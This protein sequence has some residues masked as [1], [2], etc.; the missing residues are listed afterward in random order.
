MFGFLALLG[1]L[2]TAPP[3]E[4]GFCMCAVREDVATELAEAHAV[5]TGRVVAV[6]DTVV[7]DGH[8][9]GPRVRQVT[10]RVDR[11]WKGVD[12]STVVVVTGMS[13]GSCGFRFRRG[14]SYL[15]FAHAADD[16]SLVTG[17]CDRTSRL[18]RAAGTLRA[19]GEP[20]RRWPR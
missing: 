11:A 17:L 9:P 19:L 16:G 3:C 7:G 15:V 12:S 20:A 5:F 1:A 13:D 18:W 8:F 14:A 4:T 2:W 10:L 6:G